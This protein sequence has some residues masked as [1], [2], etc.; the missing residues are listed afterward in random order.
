MNT[1]EIINVVGLC[2][3]AVASVIANRFPQSKLGKACAVIALV[4]KHELVPKA[5]P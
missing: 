1:L 5:K 2:L 3:Y 4:T